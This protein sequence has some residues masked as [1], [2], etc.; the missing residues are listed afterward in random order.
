VACIYS[1]T[2]PNKPGDMSFLSF[3]VLWQLHQSWWKQHLW[4][5]NSWSHDCH[6]HSEL[7][8]HL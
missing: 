8:F 3:S 1:A 4:K 2:S 7:V 6:I 5:V